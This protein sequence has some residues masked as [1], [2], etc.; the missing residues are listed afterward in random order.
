[1]SPLEVG[2]KTIPVLRWKLI[3]L[4]EKLANLYFS[5]ADGFTRGWTL[6]ELLAPTIVEFFSLEGKRL[7][8]KQS[9]LNQLHEVTRIAIT[10]LKGAQLSEFSVSERLSW[11]TNRKTKRDED[12]AYSLFGLFDLHLPLLYG[13]GRKKAFIRLLREIQSEADQ[14]MPHS[15]EQDPLLPFS[16]QPTVEKNDQSPINDTT[17]PELIEEL[18]NVTRLPPESTFETETF[19]DVEMPQDEDMTAEKRTEQELAAEM[20]SW[21]DGYIFRNVRPDGYLKVAVLLIKWADKLDDLGTREE[22]EELE[23]VFRERFNF[24]TQIVELDGSSKPQYQLNRSLSTFVE[25]YDGPNNLLIVYYSGHGILREDLGYLELSATQI[26]RTFLRANWTKAE[27]ILHSDDV[28]SDIL[29]IFDTAYAGNPMTGRR[30]IGAKGSDQEAKRF[31]LMNA[32]ARNSTTSV[33]GPNSFTRA[34]IDALIELVNE[35]GDRSF[36]TFVLNQRILLDKRRHHQPSQL[37]SLAG[38]HERH[39]RLA[40]LNNEANGAESVK[41]YTQNKTRG[42]VD[43]RLSLR[44][45]SLSKEQVEHLAMILVNALSNK[46][47]LGLRKIDWLGFKPVSMS[48]WNVA[49]VMFAIEKWKKVVVRKRRGENTEASQA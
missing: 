1:M 47:A 26:P 2:A 19:H 37:W 28:D 38:K 31:E 12:R 16:D 35:N 15:I 44:D 39:I 9:L 18:D 20:Q 17:T 24:R 8:D 11:A 43:L 49:L 3:H 6:Q 29:T 40:R 36:T 10:A 32:A 42:Y 30:Q 14:D 7:G 48:L 4:L 21:W 34:L 22:V 13:E 23:G 45:A 46:P 41:P 27:E 5:R 33:P 25:E